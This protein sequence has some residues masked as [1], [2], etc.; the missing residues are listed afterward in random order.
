MAQANADPTA[1]PV[2]AELHRSQSSPEGMIAAHVVD[3]ISTVA[4]LEKLAG[5]PALF[6]LIAAEL[7]YLH[8]VH[9]ELGRP[10]LPHPRRGGMNASNGTASTTCRLHPSTCGAPRR[11]CGPLATWLV[12]KTTAMPPSGAAL[13][14]RRD[15]AMSCMA[16]PSR[17]LAERRS[18]ASRPTPSVP[19][20]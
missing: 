3:L 7:A 9:G 5:N 20:L 16:P 14:S 10:A 4:E 15:C 11:A 13:R 19:G 2:S 17:K 12:P 1:I 18:T 6:R 8:L